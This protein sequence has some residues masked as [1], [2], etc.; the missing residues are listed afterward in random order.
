MAWTTTPWTL[1]SNVALTVNPNETYIKARQGDDV[2]ILAEALAKDVLG[3]DFEIV[4]RFM[5]KFCKA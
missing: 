2:C 3:E 4:D 5:G 1:P